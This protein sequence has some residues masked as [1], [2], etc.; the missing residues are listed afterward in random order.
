MHGMVHAPT[1]YFT[2]GATDLSPSSRLTLAKARAAAVVRVLVARAVA[3]LVVGLRRGGLARQ[4][5][6]GCRLRLGGCL[7]RGGCLRA[8][9]LLPLGGCAWQWEPVLPLH[10]RGSHAGRGHLG[11]LR[12][13]LD[14]ACR[15]AMVVVDDG[16]DAAVEHG[17]D[18]QVRRGQPPEGGARRPAALPQ[19]VVEHLVVWR[20]EVGVE[21]HPLRPRDQQ[22]LGAIRAVEVHHAG[23]RARHGAAR[24][25]VAPVVEDGHVARAVLPPAGREERWVRVE[26]EVAVEPDD[27]KLCGLDLAEDERRL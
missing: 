1:D 11:L 27:G 21:G 23:A 25:L 9:C 15:V 3:P 20:A 2:R 17:E 18:A 26:L 5:R 7:L 24:A 14:Q 10:G 4:A 12:R 6:L 13:V 8:C 22:V 16:H 19:Q